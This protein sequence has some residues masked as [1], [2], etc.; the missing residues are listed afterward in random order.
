MHKLLARQ[1]KRVLGVEQ[2][3]L[4]TLFDEF[5]RLAGSGTLSAEAA[6]FLGGLEA[7][8]PKV[9]EAYQQ[10]DRDLELKTRSL[11]LSSVELG[12]SNN[13][14]RE[15]LVSRTRVIDSLRQTARELMA[16]MDS[17]R[18]VAEDDSLETLSELMRDLVRQHDKSQKDL[19]RALADLA[20]Q[21]FA[22]D[23]HAIVSTTNVAGEIIYAN[24][25]L[26][27]ISGYARDE[28]IGQNHRMLNSGLQPAAFFKEMW[29]TI[30][31]GKV[32]HGEICNRAKAGHL[33]WVDAT[34]VPLR[35]EQGQPVMFIAI[36]TDITERKRMESSIKAA[37]ARLL[38]ITNTV[39]G[40]VFQ[41]QVRQNSW[42]YTF[43][44][45]RIQD[46][47]GI[48]PQ[49]LMA[50]SS[51]A[52]RQI[53]EHD[54]QRV[55]E[56]I[57]QAARTRGS[58]HDEYRV[59]LPNGTLRWMRTEMNPEPELSPEGDAIF[60]GI[61]QDVTQLK[62][63]DAR[64]NEITENIPVA[65]F[66][67]KVDGRRI[68][69][70]FISQSIESM[71]GLSPQNAV[72]HS[73]M[74]LAQVH[75]EDR[76]QLIETLLSADIEQQ[77]W[78]MDFRLI[79]PDIEGLGLG[80]DIVWVHA[81]AQPRPLSQ[82]GIA[83]N[84]YLADVTAA[85]ASAANLQR[86]ME[87]AK[88]ASQA[89]SDFLANMSHEIRTPMNGVIGMTE[90]LLD[91][92]LDPEQTEYLTIVRSSADAL[93]RVINDILDFSKIEAGKLQIEH[94]PFHLG[95]SVADTLKTIA[96]R[97]HEKGLELVYDLAPDIPMLVLGDPGR[98]RQILINIIGNAIKFTQKGEVVLKVSRVQSTGDGTVLQFSVSD[99]GIGIPADKLSTI[100]DAFSQEDSS[101]TRKYGGT[102]LGLTICSRLV[103]A[104]GG[105]IWVESQLGK[106]S[107]F[108]FTLRLD[109]DT[110]QQAVAEPM[111][112][113]DGMQVLVVDDNGVN[114]RVLSGAL[115][116]AGM[117]THEVDSGP[118]AL[119]WLQQAACATETGTRCDLVLLDA[120]MPGMNGFE[121]ADAFRKSMPLCARVPLIMLSSG[122]LKGDAQRAAD[123]GISAYLSK[124]IAREELLQV[125][126]RTLDVQKKPRSP[127][128]ITRH[129]VAD[130]QVRM[131]ILLV[132]DNPINQK[133]ALT[134]LQRWGHTVEVADNGQK[135]L[136][137]LAQ[138]RFDLI[139]MDMMMPVMDGLEATRRI[140]AEETTGHIPIIALT[141]NAMEAD[142]D[143]CLAA[144]MDEY[145][146]KPLKAADLQTMLARFAATGSVR[147]GGESKTPLPLVG[148]EAAA[149]LVLDGG[150][151]PLADFD[152]AT[153]MRQ[154]DQE[155]LEI[156]LEPFVSAWPADLQKMRDALAHNDAK[157]LLHTA[158]SLKGT[159]AMFG[160][161][162]ASEIAR[163]LEVRASRSECEGSAPLLEALVQEV[164]RLL[165]T[166]HP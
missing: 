133:L 1:I 116:A 34:I 32:W 33:Y 142:R 137:I 102:G 83:W 20:Y 40:V 46:V 146:S 77:A 104:M 154:V 136:D 37:E 84:G 62:E 91:T 4:P 112:R 128:L 64:L 12:E 82:G 103:E 163:Q 26:C 51:L 165:K 115:Q 152:Y 92:E 16:T 43:V 48:S 156:V 134:L 27:E 2:E 118:A 80:D 149:P 119:E 88:A 60:T 93:L 24:D 68:G 28:L 5:K 52:T 30:T 66:Q 90:L 79:R 101:I 96:L 151:L 125:M 94:I 81:E 157:S 153:A 11:E 124:P 89:K 13:R 76:R 164:E 75:V 36:R 69:I 100:F 166:I 31:D 155:V 21:K 86:A 138:Q 85:K 131:S 139:L 126:A 141:A 41:M 63:A 148:S 87:D 17:E 50:D 65:V 107:V 38:H 67:Y 35:D 108:H 44:S 58:W 70:S 159:L 158:H 129:V 95:R 123:A 145:L 23:Q 29:D 105:R 14:L 130:E 73:E 97:A 45:T 47:R 161:R 144:G 121:V 10:S 140:R 127:V 110:S 56:G 132:E 113:F 6:Q 42:R 147:E 106:G 99:S 109:L 111:V 150:A 39:P 18:T 19:H 54:S 57:L 160:A 55:V 8:L 59:C 3:C 7:F 162:P 53:V 74:F 61:W 143:R 98:L 117:K 120:Q 78:M 71:C 49:A 114:R 122:A 25:K 72:Q 15:E 135:A 22:L 9:D